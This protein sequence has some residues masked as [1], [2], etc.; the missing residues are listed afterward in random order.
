MIDVYEQVYS[1]LLTVQKIRNVEPKTKQQIT[2][3]ILVVRPLIDKYMDL[4][5]ELLNI[6]V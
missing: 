5:I 1:L 4:I 6:C 3:Y 2:L